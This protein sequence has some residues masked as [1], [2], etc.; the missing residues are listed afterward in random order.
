MTKPNKIHH[1]YIKV[2]RLK[3]HIA[4]AAHLQC[5]DIYVSENQL[6][7]IKN[8]HNAELEQLG[9][10]AEVYVKT[11]IENYNEIREGSNNSILLVVFEE[12]CEEHNTAAIS[13]NYSVDNGFWE[14]KTAQPRNTKNLLRKKKIW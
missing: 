5:A 8:K 6:L 13:M 2:G 14:V 10:T 11:I 4:S 12:G 9:L 3:A 7:H 1:P